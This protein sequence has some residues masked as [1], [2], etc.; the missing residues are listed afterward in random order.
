MYFTCQISWAFPS[1]KSFSLVWGNCWMRNSFMLRWSDSHT[2][3]NKSLQ[4][5]VWRKPGNF[6]R[7]LLN[8]EGVSCTAVFP[9]YITYVAAAI[10][11]ARENM[12]VPGHTNPEL[13]GGRHHSFLCIVKNHWCS[14]PEQLDLVHCWN[15]N[16]MSI[17][18][19]RPVILAA[20]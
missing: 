19:S 7:A 16:F 4:V 10:S 3:R 15:E 12:Y 20:F 11:T 6:I 14:L 1:L 17:Y 2:S 18:K 5:S 13:M 8:T 9:I